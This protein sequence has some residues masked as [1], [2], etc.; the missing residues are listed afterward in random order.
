[1]P[2][3]RIWLFGAAVAGSLVA[4][5]VFLADAQ[6]PPPGATL[7]LTHGTVV[8]PPPPPP[9]EPPPPPPPS[10]GPMGPLK[11]SEANPRYFASP[12]GR[13]VLLV[14]SPHWSSLQDAG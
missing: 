4:P 11:K 5:P 10:P 6:E 9:P 3:K 1:M 13:P 8:Q 2:T 7:T 12:D 14:G